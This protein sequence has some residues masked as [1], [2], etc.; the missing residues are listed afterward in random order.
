VPLTK[1]AS[2]FKRIHVPGEESVDLAAVLQ[3]EA[4]ESLAKLLGA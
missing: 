2:A 1:E 4:K 3:A